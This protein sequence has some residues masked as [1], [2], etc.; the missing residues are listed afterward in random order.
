M[1]EMAQ[2]HV[3]QLARRL[4]G[5]KVAPAAKHLNQMVNSIDE[6]SFDNLLGE[7][8]TMGEDELKKVYTEREM[9]PAM[10]DEDWEPASSHGLA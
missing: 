6:G 7:L 5:G 2:Y 9:E 1:G 3:A 10:A 4:Y 8:K